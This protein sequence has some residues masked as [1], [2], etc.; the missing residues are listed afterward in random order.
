[1]DIFNLNSL[2]FAVNNSR[3][4]L[5]IK[6]PIYLLAIISLIAWFS[7][8]ISKKL[9]IPPIVI[10][11]LLGAILGV[12]SLG[13]ITRDNQ[14]I[15]LEKV[16]LLFI[17]FIAGIKMDLSDLKKIGSRALI[18]GLL[19]FSLPLITGIITGKL[20]GYSWLACL[21][22][23]TIYSPHVLL[24]YPIVN[25]LGIGQKESINVAVGGTVITSILTLISLAIAQGIQ[26]GNLG[27]FLWIKLLILL[28]VFILFCFWLTPKLGR[29]IIAKQSYSNINEFIFILT[30][31]FLISSI[32]IILGVD[33]IVGAF[34]AGLAFNQLISQHDTLL[35]QLEIFANSIFI[36]AFMISVG[37]LSNPQSIMQ[38]P[39]SLL[40]A[41][42]L[43][44]G[45]VL[46][47]LIAA[48]LVGK[49]YNYSWAEIN[50]MAGLT[51]AR[52]A[53]VL[54]IALYAQQVNIF[55]NN[56]FNNTIVYAIITCLISPFIVEK[57]ALKVA[58][59]Q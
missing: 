9:R 39:T 41:C 42:V 32:T 15:L 25:N 33:A 51:M 1:M 44:L 40:I 47:K 18:F 52:A 14:L 5:P 11:I 20:L 34:I 19:T 58:Q 6:E 55:D 13:F 29:K 28:P 56:L 46:S 17:M 2:I 37:V 43:I 16:G 10:L 23:A 54:V 36:P 35:K 59:Q 21:L 50:V 38:Q 3:S 24:S 48:M 27:I 49:L 8:I 26:S 57:F 31:L 53:I 45:A 4:F 22:L 7:P 12:N 30:S